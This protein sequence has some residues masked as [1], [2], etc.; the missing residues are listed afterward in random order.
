MKALDQ[1]DRAV[2]ENHQGFIQDPGHVLLPPKIDQRVQVLLD[3]RAPVHKVLVLLVAK[4]RLKWEK[5]NSYPTEISKTV[6][7]MYNKAR[8]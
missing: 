2:T 1:L 3:P 4:K 6:D 8:H 7:N 5:V